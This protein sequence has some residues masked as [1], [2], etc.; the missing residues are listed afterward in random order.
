M[1]IIKCHGC[2]RNLIVEEA[3]T[4]ECKKV[5]DYKIEGSTLWLF[6]GEKWYPRKLLNQ[7]KGNR[8]KNYREGTRTLLI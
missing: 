2:G 7:L 4:H 1:N 6:D 3:K 8:H 5:V